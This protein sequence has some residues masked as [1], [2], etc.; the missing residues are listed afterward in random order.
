MCPAIACLA[1]TVPNPD[2]CGCPICAPADGGSVKDATT[3]VCLALPCALPVC[4]A[5]Y[6]LVTHPCA[7]PTCEPIDGGQPDVVGCP[8][9]ACP[10]IACAGGMVPNPDPCGCPLCA[11]L[12]AAPDTAKLA[13]VDLAE[14]TCQATSGCSPIAEACYCPQCGSDP[15]VCKCSGGRF[16][17]CAPASLATCTAAKARVA[18]LCP[19][20]SGTIW[21][22]LCAQS[23]SACATKCLNEVN[24]C[25]D[26]SC[27]LCAAC[28]CAGDRYMTCLGKCPSALAR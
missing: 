7:C 16:L 3:D 25:G 12:D 11:P 6:Q 13:C 9:V 14:C 18:A 28:D 21:D 4:A 27:S 2:P 15:D 8:P 26:M 1:G 24:A 23:D 17:G 22:N 10:A 19:Q 5:G 20:F